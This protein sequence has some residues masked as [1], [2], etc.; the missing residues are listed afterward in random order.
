MAAAHDREHERCRGHGAAVRV[1]ARSRSPIR[2]RLARAREV[3]A[4]ATRSSRPTSACRSGTGTR[5]RRRSTCS[6]TAPGRVKLDDRGRRRQAVGRRSSSRRD[7]A[8][9]R[10][11]TRWGRAAGVRRAQ[12]GPAAQGGTRRWSPG[13]VGATDAAGSR[14]VSRRA[15]FAVPFIPRDRGRRRGGGA[16]GGVVTTTGPSRERPPARRLPVPPPEAALRARGR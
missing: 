13:L 5:S 11:G 14:R 16:R 10:G 7:H 6:S 1:R 8:R 9:L 3:R 15:K 12:H 4:S 2:D